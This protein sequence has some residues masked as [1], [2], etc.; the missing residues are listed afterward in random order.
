MKTQFAESNTCPQMP[1]SATHQLVALDD[2][3]Y[4]S[5]C[6]CVCVCIYHLRL[7]SFFKHILLI[8]LLQL[9][10][11]PPLFPSTL[12]LPATHILSLS[13]CPW[14]VHISS[15][16]ST[17]PILFLTSPCLFCTS[18]SATYSLYL[19][20]LSPPPTHLLITLHVIS[21]SV[22]LFLF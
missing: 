16:A 14:V 19:S 20:S 22:I 21:S 3:F 15:L 11:I 2:L 13:S 17:F 6:V 12:Q 1:S 4:P 9:S 5:L 7:G 18:I 10:H 8:I